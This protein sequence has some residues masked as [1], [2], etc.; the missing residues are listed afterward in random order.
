MDP[1]IIEGEYESLEVMISKIKYSQ[2][3]EV[4][5]ERKIMDTS[6]YNHHQWL[7]KVNL[8]I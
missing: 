1:Y 6:L 7:V 3:R 2:E 5:D 4:M 8:S